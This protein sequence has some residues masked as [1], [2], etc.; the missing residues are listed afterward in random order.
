MKFSRHAALG[1]AMVAAAIS[2]TALAGQIAG[3]DSRGLANTAV[4]NVTGANGG[5][6]GGVDKNRETISVSVL[7]GATPVAAK[8]TLTNEH[9]DW[10][11]ST[12][13]TVTVRRSNTALEVKCEAAGYAPITQSIAATTIKIPKPHFH[14][15]TDAGGDG[16]GDSDE[17]EAMISVPN[18][19]PNITVVMGPKSQPAAN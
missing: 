2:S 1:A 18:Y 15:S 11:L 10:S 19:T 16:D 14:F 13:D 9:G 4:V 6:N 5:N 3:T 8:C 7:D 12:P 17:A